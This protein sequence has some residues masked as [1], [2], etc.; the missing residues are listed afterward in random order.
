MVFRGCPQKKESCYRGLQLTVP[1]PHISFDL[2]VKGV[3]IAMAGAMEL[4][5]QLPTI[6]NTEKESKF[7][8]IYSV[9]GPGRL[10]CLTEDC[11]GRNERRRFTL[12]RQISFRTSFC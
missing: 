12:E 1:I 8:V 6:G 3:N 10:V 9:S 7:G 11:V 2:S 4:A 5:R